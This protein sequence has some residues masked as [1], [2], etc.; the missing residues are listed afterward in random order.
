MTR[1]LDSFRA[2]AAPTPAALAVLV[3]LAGAALLEGLAPAPVMAQ[4]LFSAGGIGVPTGA[5]DGRTRMLGG[6]GLGL[7]GGYYSPTDPAAA[8]WL[9][10][11][12]ISASMESSS[13]VFGDGEPTGRTRFPFVGIAYPYRGNVYSLGVTGVLSQ[14]LRTE[15]ERDIDFGN[16][17]VVDAIDRFESQAGIGSAQVGMARQITPSLSAGANLG[18]Y[19]G[20][21]E[22]NFERQLDPSDVGSEV[23]FFQT[24]GLWRAEGN[25]VTTSVSWQPGSTLRLGAGATWSGDLD[26]VPEG[27]T[28][29][30]TVS[31][32]LPLVLRL[33]GYAAL[34]P[35]LGLT[36]S[37]SRADWSDAAAALN[38]DG[39]PGTVLQWGV[40]AEWNGG[41]VRNRRVP[42][43][44]G[45]R[46]G[47]LPFS[48]LG[49]AASES[50]VT[51]GFGIHLAETEGIP[52]AL[53][54]VGVERGSRA[55]GMAEETFWRTTVTFRI[56]AR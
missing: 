7:S 3:V 10:L 29:G 53:A 6:V 45:Y 16:G 20:T 35:Q 49:E 26:L 25:S 33:G 43:A 14:E 22:R 4:S 23:E 56:S 55:A 19:L 46:S 11:P 40:G 18:F 38:D 47:D 37:V 5:P 42:L 51:G 36:A 31:V 30:E 34:T 41:I 28:T 27:A 13:E 32:P 2:P 15:V 8:G 21:V 39:A 50:A 44:L 52:L 24:G 48:F 1:P 9:V 54:H 17:L 12:G